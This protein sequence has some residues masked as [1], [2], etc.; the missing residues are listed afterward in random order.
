[1]EDIIKTRVCNTCGVEKPVAE[2]VA[3]KRYRGGYMPCCKPC[4]NEYWRSHRASSPEARR[5]H[6]ETVRRSRILKD[7]G[8][9]QARYEQMLVA[10]NHRCALCSAQE[11]GRHSRWGYWNIDHCHETGRV[12][13]LLCHKC[14]VAIGYYESLVKS[15]GLDTLLAYLAPHLPKVT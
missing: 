13:G 11:T 7:Y 15:V 8:I 1:M 6:K 5:R 14:N 4:R 2:M 10:Q 3:S 9:S 12:R